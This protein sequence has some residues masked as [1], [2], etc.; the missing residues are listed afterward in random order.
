MMDCNKLEAQQEHARSASMG[1]GG[2]VAILKRVYEGEDFFTWAYHDHAVYALEHG[3]Y[4]SIPQSQVDPFV[5]VEV[6]EKGVLVTGT[7]DA[8]EPQPLYFGEFKLIPGRS[9]KLY[10]AEDGSLSLTGEFQL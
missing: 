2:K 1:K 4:E 5:I 8:P 10:V 3:H 7:Q 9:Y 6:W